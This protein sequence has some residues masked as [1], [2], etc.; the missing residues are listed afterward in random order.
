MYTKSILII[1]GATL[2]LSSGVPAHAK[3]LPPAFGKELVPDE[4]ADEPSDTYQEDLEAKPAKRRSNAQRQS[5][6][7]RGPRG[8]IHIQL[9][10][11]EDGGESGGDDDGI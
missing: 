5:G 6:F 9:D 1:F 10:G 4:N 7:Q 8:K 3:P 11:D 2:Y